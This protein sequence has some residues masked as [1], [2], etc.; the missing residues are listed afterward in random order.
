MDRLLISLNL[1]KVLGA[2]ERTLEPKENREL[3]NGLLRGGE[4][5]TPCRHGCRFKKVLQRFRPLLS[6][7]TGGCLGSLDRPVPLR[8]VLGVGVKKEYDSS[9]SP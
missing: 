9:A 7:Q 4:P 6:G 8:L 3:L 2:E 1:T 5:P